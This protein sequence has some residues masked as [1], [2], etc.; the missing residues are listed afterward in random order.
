MTH[1]KQALAFGA[2]ATIVYVAMIFG[3]LAR[4]TEIAGAPPLDMRPMGYTVAE[5]R[6]FLENLGAQGRSLYL[7]R[8]IPLDLIYPAL[9]VLTLTQT[10][11]WTRSHFPW[12]RLVTLGSLCAIVAGAADYLENMG[13]V[14]MLVTWPDPGT[15]LVVATSAASVTKSIATTCAVSAMVVCLIVRLL[16]RNRSKVAV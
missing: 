6:L 10:L 11:A 5:A 7:W 9:L 14:T 15:S 8:Q 16:A 2:A 1:G 12:P 13:I 4:L 3:P